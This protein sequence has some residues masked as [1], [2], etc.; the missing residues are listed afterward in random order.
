M[1]DLQLW[2]AALG[3]LALF[4]FAGWLLSLPIRNVSIVDS[5]WSLMF[6]LAALTYA[7][8]LDSIGPRGWLVVVLVGTWAI[9]LAAYIT[10]RNHGHGEDFR[11]QQIRANN[12][13]GFA[14]KSLY[15]VF[16]LQAALAWVISL[17][18][19]AAVNST[20]PLG[21]LDAAGVA[22]WLVGLVF[23]AGGDWQL[24]RFKANPANRGKVLDTGLWR[25]TRHPNYFGDF[26]VWWGFFL[27]AVSAGGWWSVAGPL[28]MSFLLLKVSGVA[29]LE[30]DIGE[31]R[32]AYRDYVRRTNAFF[33]GPRRAA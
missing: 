14:F 25:Y 2:G 20:A 32:P 4:A 1:F 22:L 10:W 31:R 28:V 29:L 6:L 8:E 5:M 12:Q 9:R 23:E 15:I 11:Y 7:V 27:I 21:W 18:L 13:P 19:L 30:K 17:P 16:G 3:V 33:P 26:C 24:S